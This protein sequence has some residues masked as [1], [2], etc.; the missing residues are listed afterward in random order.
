METNILSL[1]E[2]LRELRLE[3]IER[4]HSPSIKQNKKQRSQKDS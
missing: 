4:E 2:W 3:R 1:K